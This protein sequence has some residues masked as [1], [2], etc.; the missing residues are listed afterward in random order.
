MKNRDAVHRNAVASAEERFNECLMWQ[1]TEGLSESAPEV[2]YYYPPIADSAVTLVILRSPMDQ[3][4][5]IDCVRFAA[6]DANVMYATTY[7]YELQRMQ[8]FH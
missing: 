1:L 3:A 8:K 7:R 2:G 4:T 6:D 5:Q